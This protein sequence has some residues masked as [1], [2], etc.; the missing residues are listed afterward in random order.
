MGISIRSAQLLTEAVVESGIRGSVLT[1]G[2]Q[3]CFFKPHELKALLKRHDLDMPE[4]VL[5]SDKPAL[6]SAGFI[7]PEML[8]NALGFE[9]YNTLDASD[10]EGC[11][12]TFDLNSAELTADLTNRFDFIFDGGTIE[13]VFHIPNALNNLGRMLRNDGVIY[14]ASPTNNL[15]DHSFYLFSPTF[16][17]DFYSE[18]KWEIIDL[19]LQSN[20]RENLYGGT[21]YLYDYHPE[22]LVELSMGGLDDQMYHTFCIARKK[23]EST[24]NRIP[25]QGDYQRYNWDKKKR[26]DAASRGQYKLRVRREI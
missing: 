18:N 21:Y 1:L 7:S 19:F 15:I 14:H 11:D 10:Y 16:F 24:T 22:R 2:V 9:Q 23:A 4:D 26:T 25:Q 17:L 13:H 5:L 8:F 3:D 12:L 20:H 6:R